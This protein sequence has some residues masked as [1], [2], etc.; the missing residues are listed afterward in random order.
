MRSAAKLCVF[1]CVA[2]CVRF[3]V[4]RA[5]VNR[6]PSQFVA[7]FLRDKEPSRRREPVSFA[8]ADEKLM[9][10]MELDQRFGSAA[11]FLDR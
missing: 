10:F 9:A 3:A 5:T 1:D 2:V 7:L 4:P 11:N 6:G 8:R